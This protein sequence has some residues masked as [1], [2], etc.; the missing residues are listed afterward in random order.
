[1]TN[2]SS[3]DFDS[4]ATG[5]PTFLGFYSRRKPDGEKETWKEACDRFLQGLKDLGDFSEEEFSLIS[6]YARNVKSLPSGRWLW[7]GGSD[8]LKER[9]N[10]FGA[11]NCTSL[12][13]NGIGIFGVLMELSMM[14][15]GTGA[16]LDPEYIKLLP[17][18][19]NPISIYF[20]GSFGSVPKS[21]R[22]E[23]SEMRVDF[24]NRVTITVGDSREGWV[25]SYE[26]LLQLASSANFDSEIIV[27]IDISH[28]R[29]SGEALEG[30]GGVANPI[31][32]REMYAKCANILN[33]AIGRQLDSLECCLLI[34]EASAAIVAGNVR[35]SAGMRQ[36]NSA[37]MHG[38]TAKDNL[39]SQDATGKWIIDPK[40]DSLRMANH[41]RVFHR[42]PTTQECFDAV[43]KQYFSSEGAIQNAAEAIARSNADILNTPEIKN[44]F[45]EAYEKG[46]VKL[47]IENRYPEMSA[48][49]VAH[50]LSR[51]GLNPCTTSDTWVHTEHGARQ[52]KDLIGNQVAVYVNGELF[53]TTPDGFFLTGVKPV[54]KVQ[55]KEGY[56]LRLTENHQVLKVTTQTQYKQYS[57]WCEVKDLIP[58]DKILIHDHKKITP[59]DGAGTHSE[60]WL[61]GSLIGDGCFSVN[62]SNS[63]YQA[64]LRYWGETQVEMKDFA[65]S[66][67][68]NL[69]KP[70]EYLHDLK[71]TYHTAN[72]YFQVGSA[73]L[74]K[75][76]STFGVVH[77][78][79]KV[80]PE[81]EQASYDFYRGFL[82][83]IFDADGSVQG[84]H[85]KGIS[86]RLAQS[87]LPALEAIQRML[88]RV[89]I[90]SKV[91]KNRRAEGL[92]MLPNSER[93][94]SEYFCKA[95]HELVISKDNIQVFQQIVG[96][97]EPRKAELLKS[98]LSGYGRNLNRERFS[99]NIESI[100]PDGEESVY[101]CTVPG[102]SRFDANGFVAHNCGEIIGSD[103]TCNLS[104]V[105]LNQLDPT[106]FQEQEEAF[107]VGA[108]SVSALL[109]HEFPIPVMQRSRELDPIV[110]VSFTGAFDFFVNVLGVD[111]LRWWQKDRCQLFYGGIDTKIIQICAKFNIDLEYYRR[112][113]QYQLG[114]LFEAIEKAYLS[115][116]QSIVFKVVA[117]YCDRHKLKCPNRCTT[118][119][120][121]GCLDKTA[122][123]VFDQGLLYADE[124]MSPGS[125]E[126]V[127][128]KLSVRKGISV[129]TGIANQPLQLV[130]VILDNGRIL[131]MTPNHRLSID[132][133][134]VYAAD[135]I[136]G[137]KIDF[138]L[139]E[140]Q[141]EQEASLLNM[142]QFKY[143]REGRQIELG[144]S[145]GVTAT[146]IKMPQ[147]MSP[148][149]SYFIGAL[150]GDG[151]L[152]PSKY[153]IRFCCNDY[154]LLERLQKIGQQNF[155][156]EGQI[157]KYSDR[158]AFE[159]SFA[160][161]QF[162][163]WLQLNGLAKTE[164]SQNL[165]RIPL[166]IRCS[167]RQSILSFFCG[168][169]DT[170]GCIR[171]TERISI[172][173][174]SEKFLRN[175]QQIGESVG[176]CFSIFHNTQGKNKQAQKNMW[177]LCLSRMLSQPDALAYLN[178]NSQK[179]Q[180]RPI[181]S[182]KRSFKFQPYTVVSVDWEETPEYSYDFAVEGTDDN[183][184]WYWQG[185]VKSHNTKS[186]L[187]GASAGWHPPKAQ[188]Y[189]R[190][191]TYT[192]NHP[193]ALACRDFG[194]NIIPA[195]SS[196][197]ENGKLLDDIHDPRCT[198]WLVEIPVSVPWAD[199]PGAEDIDVAQFS[200]I[201]Q[202]D[203]YMRVQ[204]EWTTHNTSAT[205][206]FREPEIPALSLRIHDAIKNNEGFI[207]VALMA[208]FDDYNS[209]PRL[210]FE[211]I[212]KEVYEQMMS[213]VL[214][215]RITNNFYATFTRYDL[216]SQG[217]LIPVGPNG[218]DGD[219]CEM[220]KISPA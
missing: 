19:K 206:E 137:M 46:E 97:Q 10:V 94:P 131:R 216:E 25:R 14:G 143:T 130:K 155:A 80:T 55:T 42:K 154:A 64:S 13:L 157:R 124:L 68:N 81:I 190:R 116:W 1:M 2:N 114:M 50:R 28:V 121:S 71:G 144:H 170:D 215:R 204:Q 192:A 72:K 99:V 183:D 217:M 108:L 126:T 147:I 5:L 136:P 53:S 60:G 128:L 213:D 187:T 169:I 207:S 92:R 24:D 173:S 151:C 44:E 100:S 91:Y 59:W 34:D 111:W 168:L 88:L 161:I 32:L 200:A 118:V 61:I 69:P 165:D 82:R 29:K 87:D 127:N 148:D 39:W 175:L 38:L 150:F 220:P 141:N 83:G 85:E 73:S 210:P 58:G 98:L 218:C 179:A 4:V 17:V 8:W 191:I 70:P 74:A 140:Y 214:E 49:E 37:D 48:E 75:L 208:R 176:L 211:P 139:G 189:I 20:T 193:V 101:D 181:P 172:D 76:A 180:T 125:G 158:E 52:V 202:F 51:F 119:Q 6:K 104:E 184:S 11:Y 112:D 212:S 203:F 134:W 205:I 12:N 78:H 45:L 40:R 103:F 120:P 102:I 201:A 16:V 174:A 209:F 77:K 188:R 15:C 185:G 167:S 26:M 162:F 197:D 145:R 67:V 178:S 123:R 21:Q 93:V 122:L 182:P 177:G 152:S 23:T 35:R 18:I 41:S 84:N 164:E 146:I 163:D 194:Y 113:E 115:W 79:K 62:E 63:H 106:N 160:S 43:T 159:L 36:F 57:E 196:K 199:L 96:F 149:L 54:F 117:A 105:Q 65:L 153:R 195:Q 186:L 156:L 109:K 30:F 3:F 9:K 171:S 90:A 66:L 31:K 142:D 138:S 86:V 198:E 47:W 132:G 133:N 27:T 7:T 135:M 107:T 219:K 33:G 110:G 22:K 95:Q 89:G 129:S 56:S 166:A